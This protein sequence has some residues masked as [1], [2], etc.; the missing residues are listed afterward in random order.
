MMTDLE[1]LNRLLADVG[2]RDGIDL[3][4]NQEGS[5][6]ISRRMAWPAILS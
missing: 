3:K 1:Q 6:G 2:R 5:A 4:L